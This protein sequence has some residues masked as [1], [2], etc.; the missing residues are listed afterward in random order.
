MITLAKSRPFNAYRFGG[1]IFDTGTKLGFL[2]A[3]IAYAL[4]RSDLGPS[5]REEMQK[6]LLASVQGR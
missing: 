3:N 4:E 6:S 1:R 2:T 5:L